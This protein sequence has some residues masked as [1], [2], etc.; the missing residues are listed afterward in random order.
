MELSVG[1]LSCT[2][3]YK[4]E[5]G[6]F[7]GLPVA[8]LTES[9]PEAVGLPRHPP[10]AVLL[11]CTIAANLRTTAACRAGQKPSVC[12][13][14]FEGCYGRGADCDIRWI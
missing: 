8:G 1:S 10:P 11:S 3:L 2:F 13:S 12:A 14:H 5:H 7:L 4:V 9:T 6:A